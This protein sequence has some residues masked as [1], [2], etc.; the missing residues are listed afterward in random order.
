[1]KFKVSDDSAAV[2]LTRY[3][4]YLQEFRSAAGTLQN[5][6]SKGRLHEQV[7][8]TRA[9]SS[10][11]KLSEAAR[12]L[13]LERP[14]VAYR[15]SPADEAARVRRLRDPGVSAQEKWSLNRVSTSRLLSHRAPTNKVGELV[16]EVCQLRVDLVSG[17]GWKYN[18]GPFDRVVLRREVNTVL[19][20]IYLASVF[21][22]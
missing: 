18:Y 9:T 20:T 2:A 8:Y 7:L 17:R 11:F 13:R 19:A 22:P 10:V 21:E 14:V 15:G 3:F 1:M 12:A 4:M 5:Q 6:Q 16:L